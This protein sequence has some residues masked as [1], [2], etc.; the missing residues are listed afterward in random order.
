MTINQQV[1]AAERTIRETS[2]ASYPVSIRL[3]SAV[4]YHYNKHSLAE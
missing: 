4:I 1:I 2:A 3:G